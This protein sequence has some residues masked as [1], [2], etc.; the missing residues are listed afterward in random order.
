L[1]SIFS[2][3]RAS[4]LRFCS[5]LLFMALPMNRDINWGNNGILGGMD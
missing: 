2:D 4:F 3:V 5:T 1:S